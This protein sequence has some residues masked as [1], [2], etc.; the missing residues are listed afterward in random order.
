VVIRALSKRCR[1]VCAQTAL[2]SGLVFLVVGCTDYPKQSNGEYHQTWPKPYS[3][4]TC[5]DWKEQMSF[6]QQFVATADLIEADQGARTTRLVGLP[7]EELLN[8]YREAI[9]D[10]CT[11]PSA[12]LETV[13]I[14]AYEKR[15]GPL[16]T[17]G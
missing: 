6:D 15:R 3:E 14:P 9:D 12:L 7:P 10:A 16:P 13:A 1:R 4:T 17:L 5:A 8:A 2:A 11:H